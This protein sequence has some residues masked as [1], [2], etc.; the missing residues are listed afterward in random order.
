A[1]G[2]GRVIETHAP[3]YRLRVDPDDIDAARFVRLTI[4]GRAAA[5]AGELEIAA[6][7]FQAALAL[8]HGE[9]YAEFGDV[10]AVRIEADRREEMR[11]TVREERIAVELDLGS[12]V[13]LV[14]E[15]EKLLADHPH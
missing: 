11:S 1:P 3:G 8:W 9:A 14:P 4:E 12:G 10:L 13:E 5:A 15:I 2:T 7:R 6:D